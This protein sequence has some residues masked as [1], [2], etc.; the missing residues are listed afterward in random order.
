M[1][2]IDGLTLE[3]LSERAGVT[4]DE[5]RSHYPTASSCLY[6]TYEEVSRSVL[7]DFRNAFRAEPRWRPALALG[8]RT[9]LERMAAHPDEARLC[10]VEV[11]RADHELLRRR[12]AARRRLVQ[13]FGSELAR[14]LDGEEGVSELQLELLV[15]AGFQAIAAAVSE[16]RIADLPALEPELVSRATVFEP[17]P[18]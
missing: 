2:G 11:F 17:L 12:L 18:A 1:D 15:G 3:R 8:G 5:A 14:R 7:E 6:D 13:L 9:L 16:G 10:F 4:G